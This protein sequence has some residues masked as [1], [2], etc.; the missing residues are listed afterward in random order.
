MNTR[1]TI[2]MDRVQTPM[3]PV[4]GEWTSQHPGTISLG[5]GVVHYAAPSQVH[6]EIANVATNE[7]R[8]DR[9]ALVRG[10]DELLEQIDRKVERENGARLDES[11]SVVTAGSNMGF[12]NAVLA[13]ADVDEEIILLS[14]YYFNHEMAIDIAG[15]KPIIVSTDDQY[16][17]DLD[18]LV[19]AITDRTRAIVTVSPSNPT[20]V[21][22][23]REALIAVNDLCKQRG[24]YHISDEA[25]EYFLYDGTE[26][27]SPGSLPNASAHTISLYTLSKA[28]GMAGWRVGYMTIPNH[29]LTSVK[30]IQDTNL[31]CPPIMNQFA[32]T[33]ALQMGRDWCMQQI[34]EFASVRDIV[35]DEFAKLGDRCI[36]PR[37]SGAFYA[38]IKLRTDKTDMELVE[39]LIRDFGIAVLPGCT[40]G[41][42]DPCSIRIAYGA[43][44][45]D[46]VAEGMG[47]LVRGLTKLL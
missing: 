40:F 3:I 44:A 36:V 19:A 2:R 39:S 37:P 35:V 30:K 20:G 33:K 10:I 6:T 9:Y 32:A 22:Y 38:L 29:L 4:V 13:I 17:I 5:Q 34:A 14:P 18:C 28:Y 8:I 43:L 42:H 11:T 45:K 31:V 1:M 25:Y 21:V 47:R 41:V 7:P 46:T 16:Q 27:F 23:S 26:H 12:M 15:C 24:I